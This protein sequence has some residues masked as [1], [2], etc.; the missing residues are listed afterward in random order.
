METSVPDLLEAL[1][2]HEAAVK[3][4]Y[5]TF[6][7][8]FPSRAGFWRNLA[9][10][11]QGHAAR[12]RELGPDPTIADWL[13]RESGLRPQGVRSSVVYVE[14]QIEKARAGGLGLVQALVVARDLENALI[15]EQF[16]RMS[17]SSHVAASAVLGELAAETETHR[18]L[19]ASAL[20][21]ERRSSSSNLRGGS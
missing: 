19:L 17:R 20:E 7:D 6:A 16:T 3:R 18:A 4:L 21:A 9:R 1:I 11:E 5:E 13:A 14:S 15:E 2:A 12:L 8:L 10:E